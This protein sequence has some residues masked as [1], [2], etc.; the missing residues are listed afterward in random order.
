MPAHLGDTDRGGLHSGRSRRSW[1]ARPLALA[2]RGVM[3]TAMAF[4]IASAVPAAQGTQAARPVVADLATMT[5]VITGA[6]D[7]VNVRAKPSF[8]AAVVAT[9][10]D[11]TSVRLRIA[12]TNTVL[13]PDGVTRWWPISVDGQDGWVI[14][15]YLNDPEG[16]AGAGLRALGEDG[17]NASAAASADQ[18]ASS[19]GNAVASSSTATSASPAASTAPSAHASADPLAATAR[20]AEAD[21]VKYPPRSRKMM[22]RSSRRSRPARSSCCAPM[23]PIP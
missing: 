9:V 11:G 3:V 16:V 2:A 20:V 17:G 13:D 4:S 8:D 21:G 5:A 23:S 1:R 12:D 14:G 6:S 19:S 18:A 15:Y 7:G 22:P 10:Y